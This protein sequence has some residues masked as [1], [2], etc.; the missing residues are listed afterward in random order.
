MG[1]RKK[2]DTRWVW[3]WDRFFLRE[4]VWDSETRS[5]RTP[6]PSLLLVFKVF[7]SRVSRHQLSSAKRGWCLEMAN[8]LVLVGIA[9]TRPRFD[10]ES[11]ID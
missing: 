8:K 10:G 6:L 5:C 9:R 1:M 11:R 3:G 2:F 4:W 7:V